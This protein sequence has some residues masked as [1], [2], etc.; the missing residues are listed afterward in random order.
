M[1]PR[2]PSCHCPPITPPNNLLTFCNVIPLPT[3][4]QIL[5]VPDPLSLPPMIADPPSL[6]PTTVPILAVQGPLVLVPIPPMMP[7]AAVAL[8]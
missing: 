5:V 4:V 6:V 1:F 2:I 3:I 7:L 8:V